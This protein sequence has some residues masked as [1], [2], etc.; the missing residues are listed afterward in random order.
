MS[1]I[2]DFYNLRLEE[3]LKKVDFFTSA[4]KSK[5]LAEVQ[6]FI[7]NLSLLEQVDGPGNHLEDVVNNIKIKDKRLQQ[8]QGT[9]KNPSTSGSNQSI[10]STHLKD[11]LGANTT[12]TSTAAAALAAQN[13]SK[14]AQAFFGKMLRPQTPNPPTGAPGTSGSQNT[15][16]VNNTGANT[17][18]TRIAE[19]E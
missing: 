15:Q 14:K 11:P 16:N 8:A 10:A 7:E 1:Q 19:A 18:P 17:S 6:Y 3:E 5:L 12:N 2:F 9:V 4:G 13:A